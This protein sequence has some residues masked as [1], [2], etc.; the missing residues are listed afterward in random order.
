MAVQPLQVKWP[1]DNND[2]DTGGATTMPSS[3]NVTW[4]W[5]IM[6]GTMV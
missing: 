3:D 6:W 2:D 5:T 1:V 4:G